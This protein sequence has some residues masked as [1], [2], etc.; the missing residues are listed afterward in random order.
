M[1]P[2]FNE[3][4]NLKMAK[5]LLSQL[6]QTFLESKCGT[7]DEER[8]ALTHVKQILLK[9]INGQGSLTSNYKKS[10]LDKN[11]QFRWYGNGIQGIPS[12]FRGALCR[13]LMTDID[14]NNAYPSILLNICQQKEIPCQ[15]LTQYCA[16]RKQLLS[17]GTFT[18][19][20]ILK[21]MN[22]KTKVKGDAWL[23]A[24]DTEMKSIQNHLIPHFPEIYGTVVE[25]KSKNAIGT[26]ITRVC[27]YFENKFLEAI[28]D[29]ISPKFAVAVLM[30]DGLM[31]YGN[32]PP[33]L[34]AELTALVREKFGFEIGFSFKEHDTSIVIPDDFVESD[35]K[36]MYELLK[37]KYENDYGLAYI[38]KTVAYSYKINNTICFFKQHELQQTLA[39]E[40]KFF[41]KWCSDASRK[42]YNDVGVYPP[43]VEAVEGNL[44]LWNGFAVERKE[45]PE[46]DKE[47][48]DP[49]LNHIKILVNHDQASYDFVL[50]WLAN[51]FQYPSSTSIFL[52]FAS[53][54]GTGKSLFVEMLGRMVGGDKF[55]EITN[56]TDE[57]FGSFNSQLRDVVLMNINEA[58]RA[59]ASKC[60]EKLKTQITSPT[61]QVHG[62]GEKPYTIANLRKF[63]STNNNPHA[64]VLKSGNRRY[65]ST[66]CSDELI[67]NTKYFTEFIEIT[68][69]PEVLYT[70]WKYLMNYETPK[71]LTGI[72]IPVTQLML[73][74]FKLNSDPIEDFVAD[75]P[76][77]VEIY[78]DDNYNAYK[79]YMQKSGM[80]YALNSKQ[81]AM[82]FKRAIA[83]RLVKEGRKDVMDDGERMQKRYI[84]LKD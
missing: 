8:S 56:L 59:D 58:E 21:C 54:E 18:K 32:P 30:F 80:E 67:G 2:S 31:V 45:Y 55:A 40:G 76:S 11:S 25:D 27:M 51:L 44:N 37:Q 83:T 79:Q 50:K 28:V 1:S 64:I 63:I 62:K 81:F 53:K 49:I 26:F 74:A 19:V 39:S 82:K 68:R 60:F 22:K 4:V 38:A 3:R 48:I 29:Y 33:E 14:M 24:F 15:Y 77:G 5:Y 78:A 17:R 71:Q 23:M 43:D 35:E 47:R 61:I 6:S 12:T 10:V 65:F 57:L 13:G 72:D 20:D 42:V 70:F 34:L 73:E 16:E 9:F 36:Q 69:N 52:N 66:E 75:L 7:N 84:V 41:S 46:L